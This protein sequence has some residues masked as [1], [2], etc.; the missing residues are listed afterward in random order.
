MNQHKKTAIVVGAGIAGASICLAL[1]K[2]DIPTILIDSDSG[3]AEHASGNPIGVVYPFLT[4]HKTAESEFSLQAFIYFLSIWKNLKLGTL[5]PH[6]DG[7]YFLIDKEESYDRYTHALRS[8]QILSH[9]ALEKD[10]PISGIRAIFFPEGKSLSPK[11]LTKQILNITN[12]KTKY[13]CKLVSWNELE[14]GEILCQTTDGQLTCDYLFLSQGYQF[15]DDPNSKWLPLKKV[16]GQIL[17]I[18]EQNPT[19][20]HGILYGDYLTAPLQGYQVL[21]ATYDEFKL[22]EETRPEESESMW[23]GLIQK[24]PTLVSSW[25][26][27]NVRLFPTRVSYRTQSQ[28][29]GPIVGKLPDISKI[30]LSIKYQN[31]LKKD[32]KEIKIPY[33]EQV[34]ILNGLG[35]RGLTHSLYAAE[36]LVS[37]IFKEPD[38]V[39]ERIFKYLQ[40]DRFLFRMWKR[41]QLT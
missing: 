26:L 17:K 21:G 19:N 9:I 34:G 36:I 4:K 2:R 15:E 22:E 7:I 8:H 28:D 31:R 3:P 39:S 6:K 16:R 37:S 18:P 41:D 10:E 29:R 25:N 23:E 40:P 12:P 5:I 35:S 1:K 20:T 13:N 38:I 32:G 33:F 27:P 24:L 11:D 30:D 14:N